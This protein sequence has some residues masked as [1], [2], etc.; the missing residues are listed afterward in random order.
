ML[1]TKKHKGKRHKGNQSHIICNEHAGEKT[2]ED[3][4]TGKSAGRMHKSTKA[5][6]KSPEKSAALQTRYR[7]HEGKKNRKRMQVN[8]GKIGF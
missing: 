1:N 8:I 6:R 3:Q 2:E 4:D 5:Y 7:S